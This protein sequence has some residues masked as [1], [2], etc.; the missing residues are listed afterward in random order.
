[1]KKKL[2]LA[3]Y[4]Y[5]CLATSEYVK[6]STDQRGFFLQE[7][8]FMNTNPP[9][10][11]QTSLG[12]LRRSYAT[13][14]N[15]DPNELRTQWERFAYFVQRL[16]HDT[17]SNVAYKVLYLARH[18][19][20][21]HN[22]AEKDYGTK[23]WNCYWSQMEGNGSIIWKDAKL[24]PKG[25]D[26]ALKANNFWKGR[27][28]SEKVPHPEIMYTS[29]LFRCLQTV[30]TTFSGYPFLNN[31][32]GVFV[33]ESIREP[34]NACTCAW[35]SL[36]SVM[37][38]KFPLFVFDSTMEEEDPFWTA[39]KVESQSAQ[40][41]RVTKFLEKVSRSPETFISVTSHGA[42]IKVFLEVI[43]HP[44]PK[45]NLTTGQIVPV[46][47]RTEEIKGEKADASVTP[48]TTATT[49]SLCGPT[50]GDM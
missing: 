38:A 37:R 22:I 41:L 4:T 24:T 9:D 11:A 32:R 20:A 28:V 44:N 39:G 2:L 31:S 8:P 25:H 26:H 13:D 46:L 36:K 12:L 43:G 45:F 35:R 17:D 42:L 49:C 14:K 29:P 40:E 3:F 33:S 6:F 21:Y 7:Q 5:F 15:F 50:M 34:I 16:N 23:C 18:G 27:A 19:E 47:V 30:N 48:P 1:M 10:F